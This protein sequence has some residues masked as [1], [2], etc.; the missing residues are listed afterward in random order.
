MRRLVEYLAEARDRVWTDS[1][2]NVASRIASLREQPQP[3]SK[4]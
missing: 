2:I 3:S 1:F 4:L